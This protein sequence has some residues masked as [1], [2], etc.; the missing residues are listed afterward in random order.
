MNLSGLKLYSNETLYSFLA[1]NGLMS[2]L[3]SSRRFLKQFLGATNQQLTS[4]LP[5]YIAALLNYTYED[6]LSL[7]EQHTVIPYY[8]PF[9]H[10]DV[11]QKAINDLK[12]GES[13]NL[14]GRFSLIANRIPNLNFSIIALVVL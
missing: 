5:S 10:Q 8:R 1:R 4:Q 7:V 12:T 6:F 3:P 2:G 14:Y 11:Y 9:L 13:T